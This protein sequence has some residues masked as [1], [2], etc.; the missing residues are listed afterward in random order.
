MNPSAVLTNRRHPNAQRLTDGAAALARTN[1]SNQDNFPGSE[2]VF[3]SEKTHAATRW[4]RGRPTLQPYLQGQLRDAKVP[5][6]AAPRVGTFPA[7]GGRRP[8]RR[9]LLKVT[10]CSTHGGPKVRII[11]SSSACRRS[12]RL[13]VLVARINAASA[14]NTGYS[15]HP[16]RYPSTAWTRTRWPICSSCAALSCSSLSCR[17][18]SSRSQRSSTS[19]I[20]KG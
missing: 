6:V 12:I 4:T 18:P 7:P 15:T 16:S 5:D 3:S 14:V 13:S 10:G 8:L 9:L 1:Q 20:P 17:E 11:K 19:W 2:S